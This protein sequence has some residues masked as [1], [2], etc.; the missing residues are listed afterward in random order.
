MAQF[1]ELQGTFPVRDLRQG[2]HSKPR[3][4]PILPGYPA[5]IAM[6]IS[7]PHTICD[8]AKFLPLVIDYGSLQDRI[9]I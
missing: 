4:P 7:Q 5:G 6:G 3:P 9:G 2:V 8:G 1:I